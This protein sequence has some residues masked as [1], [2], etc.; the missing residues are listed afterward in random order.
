MKRKSIGFVI[1]SL[2]RCG[3]TRIR[4]PSLRKRRF[5]TFL[6]MRIDLED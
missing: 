3:M 4:E 5:H 2:W 1:P 6:T